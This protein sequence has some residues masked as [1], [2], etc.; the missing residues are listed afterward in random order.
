MY[1]YWTHFRRGSEHAG[2]GHIGASDY[3]GGAANVQGKGASGQAIVKEAQGKG[4][5]GQVI[6]K[7][8]QQTCRARVHRCKRLQRRGSKCTEQGRIGTS[9]HE[10]GAANAQ[11]KGASVQVIAKEGQRTYRARAHWCKQLQ[12]RGSKHA[13]KGCI[14]ASDCEGGAVNAQ[15]MG[16]PFRPYGAARIEKNELG[17][18]YMGAP[19]Q[20]S[21]HL[22]PDR[23]CRT[24]TIALRNVLPASAR[25]S[26]SLTLWLA[27]TSNH[28]LGLD[29]ALM[30][31]NTPSSVYY[32]KQFM[33]DQR[34][35]TGSLPPTSQEPGGDWVSFS[36]PISMVNE[37][38]SVKYV[39]ETFQHTESGTEYAQL[40]YSLPM[41]LVEYIPHI[42]PSTAFNNHW[43]GASIFTVQ[44][45]ADQIHR[46]RNSDSLCTDEVTPGIQGPYGFGYGDNQQ[47]TSADY[48]DNN[49]SEDKLNLKQF[50]VFPQSHSNS[51]GFT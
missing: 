1:K 27:I 11:G 39:N 2:Q 41:H 29:N 19:M 16:T 51:V 35:M 20:P 50:M 15:G 21:Q 6:A 4:T 37:M 30:D 40:M 44:N 17:P 25:L 23:F 28:T 42:H 9:D 43:A 46:E 34:R 5:S 48:T 24:L 26:Q 13:G 38:F 45:S 49:V 10:G 8:G 31:N 22:L 47:C 3:K 33:Q 18:E 7:E 32:A 36:I 12:R 14:H